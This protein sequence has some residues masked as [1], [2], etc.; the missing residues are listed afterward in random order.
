MG[1]SSYQS[2]C[3]SPKTHFRNRMDPP[4]F[5]T[6]RQKRSQ[7]FR[8]PSKIRFLF[9]RHLPNLSRSQ[10]RLPNRRIP[11][12]QPPTHKI[13]IHDNIIPLPPLHPNFN[14][15]NLSPARQSNPQQYSP[16]RRLIRRMVVSN[17]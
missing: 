8:N 13:Q 7:T 5:R 3:L 12:K 16:H 15:H 11:K 10:N 4:P 14:E 1:R 9:N 6:R 2:L 17:R